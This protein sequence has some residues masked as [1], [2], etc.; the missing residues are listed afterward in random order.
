[1]NSKH[2]AAIAICTIF[3]L[4][5]TA[6]ASDIDLIGREGRLIGEAIFDTVDRSQK[7]LVHMGDMEAYR[8]DVFISMDENDDGKV[9]YA[10]FS[11]WDPGFIYVAEQ[12]GRKDAY[13][14]AS[15]IVFSFWDKNGDGEMTVREMRLAMIADLKRADQNDDAVLTK[16]EF[17]SGFPIIVAM[18]AAIRPDL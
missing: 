4:P 12:V 15:K 8:D 7:G 16:E 5:F 6:V 18:R 1:M 13:V 3:A 11:Q 9:N 2:R 10:E 14:T 17:I